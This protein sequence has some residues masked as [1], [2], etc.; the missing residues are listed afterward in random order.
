MYHKDQYRYNLSSVVIT[1]GGYDEKGNAYP[2]E[3]SEIVISKC[4]DEAGNGKTITLDD[5]N[6]LTYTAMI[7][8]PG[9]VSF[10]NLPKVGSTVRVTDENGVIRV[11]KIVRVVRKELYHSRLWV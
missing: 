10:E 5:G 2:S 11:E 4:R 1:G 3:V 7:Q 9:I 8:V 6:V